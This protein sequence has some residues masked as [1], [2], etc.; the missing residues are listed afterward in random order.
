MPVTGRRARVISI[1]V[2]LRTRDGQQREV[3]VDPK[4]YD[5]VFFNAEVAERLLAPYY[6]ARYGF[7]DALRRLGPLHRRVRRAGLT[8]LMHMPYCRYKLLT[9]D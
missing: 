8:V 9:D 3:E 2:R 4:E 5:S 1:T 7:K 6:T